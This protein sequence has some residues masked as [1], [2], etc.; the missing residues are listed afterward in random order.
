[1][2]VAW[3]SSFDWLVTGALLC[4]IGFSAQAQVPTQA[5]AQESVPPER[6]IAA[7]EMTPLGYAAAVGLLTDSLRGMHPAISGHLVMRRDSVNA[8]VDSMARAWVA[9]LT[10]HGVPHHLEAFA[11]AGLCVRAGH[12]AEAERHIATWFAAPG[13]SIHDRV[14]GLGQAISTFLGGLGVG[15]RKDPPVSFAHLAIARKYLAQLEALPRS[16]AAWTLFVARL[17]FMD[18]YLDRGIADTAIQFGLQALA[19]PGQTTDYIDQVD[20]SNGAALYGLASALSEF[21]DRYQRTIDSLVNAIR[22]FTRAPIPPKY[23]QLKWLPDHVAQA[24]DRFEGE[25]A[26][27]QTLGRPAAP[28]I[29]TH[30]FNQTPPSLSSDSAPG[31]REKRQDDGVIRIIGFGF[32]GCPG[33]Q[34]AMHD[35][36][37]FQHEL[38]AG[39]E[40]LWYERSEGFWGSDLVEPNQEAEHLRHYYVDRKHYTYPIAVWAGPKEITEEGGGVPRRSPTMNQYGMLGGPHIVIIDGHGMLRYRQWGWSERE[41]LRAVTRIARARD[42]MRP[43]TPSTS[44]S[45]SARTAPTSKAT[46]IPSST[47]PSFS[48]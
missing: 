8:T 11:M 33:C 10:R 45:V 34:L 19:L 13:I 44:T 31:A 48:R 35:W 4:V 24:R 15:H 42:H 28:L 17:E 21:P 29:A 46:V 32:F 16:T 7:P 30:W 43:W 38:P 22:P 37:Q 1:M 25:V 26:L 9:A 20:M 39:V 18:V 5:P 27:I 36:E 14:F 41:V 23:A 6:P 2:T 3:R 47:P 12:D 40:M